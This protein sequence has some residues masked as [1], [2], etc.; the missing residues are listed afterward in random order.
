MSR[1]SYK[2]HASHLHGLPLERGKELELTTQQE[3]LYL[4][5]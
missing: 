3:A 4:C 2:K 1:I 5:L